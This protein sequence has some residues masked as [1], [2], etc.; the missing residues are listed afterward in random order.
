MREV[1]ADDRRPF[2]L[3][4]LGVGRRPA[5]PFHCRRRGSGPVA[6]DQPARFALLIA[7]R[8]PSPRKDG[9]FGIR[10]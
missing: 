7:S 4:R 6:P 8:C 5:L 9:Q 3:G 2:R 1:G 10:S